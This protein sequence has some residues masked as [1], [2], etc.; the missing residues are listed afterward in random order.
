MKHVNKTT[1]QGSDSL[2]YNDISFS[3]ITLQLYSF[4]SIIFTDV[5]HMIVKKDQHPVLNFDQHV[6]FK[7]K[8]LVLEMDDQH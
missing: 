6:P 3:F 4:T 7:F 2:P 1:E 5:Q 8:E